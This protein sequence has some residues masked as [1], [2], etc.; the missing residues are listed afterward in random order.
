MDDETR[1]QASRVVSEVLNNG[2]I[3]FARFLAGLGKSTPEKKQ[4]K[5][6]YSD[7]VP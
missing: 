3:A 6:Q 2:R 4:G 1:R 7:V 5:K